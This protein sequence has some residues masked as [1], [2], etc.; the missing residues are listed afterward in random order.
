MTK[1]ELT[2]AYQLAQA[3]GAA[4]DEPKGGKL[5]PLKSPW[6]ATWSKADRISGGRG[7]DAVLLG[8][9]DDA[10]NNARLV[11]AFRGTL[12]PVIDKESKLESLLMIIRDWLNDFA[13]DLVKAPSHLKLPGMFHE[14]FLNSFNE[15]LAEKL[16]EKVQAAHSQGRRIQITGHS[17]G[18]ALAALAAFYFIKNGI[19]VDEVQTFG[20]A[21]AGDDTF[22]AA[23]YGL[24]VKH[25]RFERGNDIVPHEP[26]R[27]GPGVKPNANYKHVGELHFINWDGKL[28]E[29]T[30]AEIHQQR[31]QRLDKVLD[32]VMNPM[33][34]EGI[35]EKV[36]ALREIATLLE[37][38]AIDAHHPDLNKLRSI[39]GLGLTSYAEL[40]EKLAAS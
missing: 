6:P 12:P 35:F 21:Q 17:K 8:Y 34:V 30:E 26:E 33:R 16:L 15:L 29:R 3:S 39:P 14:G 27:G 11:V 28:D 23:Y 31:T 10:A 9:P 5:D 24:K 32:I 36:K 37:H 19:P 2:L 25:Y 22:A 4:Y 1:A 18:G 20:S 7:R 13:A 38:H 40:L